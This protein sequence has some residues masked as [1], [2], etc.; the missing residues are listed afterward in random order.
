[1]AV[2]QTFYV[3]HITEDHLGYNLHARI[4]ISVPPTVGE[5]PHTAWVRATVFLGHEIQ[6]LLKVEPGDIRDLPVE[7]AGPRNHFQYAIA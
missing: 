3:D 5:K 4:G 6:N 1:M 7:V 2:N